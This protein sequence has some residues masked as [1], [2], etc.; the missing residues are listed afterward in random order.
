MVAPV[1]F[2]QNTTHREA[3]GDAEGR[4]GV[5]A[6][7]KREG[8]ARHTCAVPGPGQGG[9]ELLQC[10]LHGDRRRSGPCRPRTV[11]PPETDGRKIPSPEF[12]LSVFH[13]RHRHEHPSLHHLSTSSVSEVSSD[14]RRACF[15]GKRPYLPLTTIHTL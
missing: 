4:P 14:D 6:G 3:D 9:K 12:L 2:R 13:P 8:P 7:Q 11:N 15:T 5:R 1:L 10:I